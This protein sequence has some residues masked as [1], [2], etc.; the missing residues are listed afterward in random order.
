MSR[1]ASDLGVPEPL[2]SVRDRWNPFEAVVARTQR[3]PSSVELGSYLNARQGR[4]RRQRVFDTGNL[5]WLCYALPN[6][7]E[8]G[9]PWRSSKFA[10]PTYRVN[11]RL[12]SSSQN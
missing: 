8:G 12:K 11:R 6:P 5:L 7:T 3:G 4:Y 1:K 9:Q 2:M 10:C